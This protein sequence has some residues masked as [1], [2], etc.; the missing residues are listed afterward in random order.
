M[1]DQKRYLRSRAHPWHGLK[2][3]PNPP[4]TV[5]AFIEITPFDLV[6][7]ELDKETGFM[8]V[9]RP[10][11]TSSLPPTLY[12]FIPRTYC[13]SAVAALMPKSQLGDQD[14]LDICVL[15]E[16]SISRGDVLL[17]VNVVG[18]LPTLDDDRADDKI[19]AVL[20]N[21]ALWGGVK[22][23]S[24]LPLA[25]INR[26]RHYFATYKSKPHEAPQVLVGEPYGA[27]HALKVVEAAMADYD[28]EFGGQIYGST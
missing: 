21:D 17:K 3:G 16:R 24:D 9:D 1:A 25:L 2:V 18:G 13:G 4:G 19:I 23:I 20:A 12:G 26:L 14:P 15:S 28:H 7:Y 6:K 27:R 22:D 8:M 10:Q 11:L 5:Y